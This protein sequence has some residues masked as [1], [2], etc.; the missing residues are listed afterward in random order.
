MHSLNLK[1][2]WLGLVVALA[3]TGCGSGSNTAGSASTS[4]NTT[5]SN[6]SSAPAVNAPDGARLLAAQCYQCHGTGGNSVSDIDS[7]AGESASEL[8]EEMLEMKYSTDLNDIMHRQAMG[9][10]EEQ[11][12]AVATYL[13][14]LPGNGGD[15]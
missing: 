10:S 15:D 14:A 5:A 7:I 4:S 12:R 2:I 6:S 8:T 9:Y 11:I 1:Q 13:A 3:V